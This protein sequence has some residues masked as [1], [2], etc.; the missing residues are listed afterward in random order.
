[1]TRC[2]PVSAFAARLQ[3]RQALEWTQAQSPFDERRIDLVCG[4][5]QNGVSPGEILLDLV[6]TVAVTHDATLAR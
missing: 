3:A 6:Q 4:G 2:Q 1:V 5:Q